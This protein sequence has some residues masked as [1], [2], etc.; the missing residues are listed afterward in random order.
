MNAPSKFFLCCALL[1]LVASSALADL[2]VVASSPSDQPAAQRLC[3]L[4]DEPARIVEDEGAADP[5]R[6]RALGRSHGA[7]RVVVFAGAAISVTD[8]AS[9]RRSAR[10]AE[11]SSAFTAAFVATELL[12]LQPAS[13]PSAASEP[14]PRLGFAL[15]LGL[16]LDR[17]RPFPLAPRAELGLALEHATWAR[18]SLRA[19]LF[20]A[21]P[22]RS[23][24]AEVQRTSSELGARMAFVLERAPLRI[25][26]AA[27]LGLGWVRARFDQA[28]YPDQ[29]R[30][31]VRAGLGVEPNYRLLPWLALYGGL[32]LQSSLPRAEYRVAGE[33]AARESPLGFTVS[34]GLWFAPPFR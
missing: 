2:L 7:A 5:E 6:A 4:H 3:E 23:Q 15:R 27:Q 34:A 31:I 13:T 11:N 26:F 29:T 18:A 32:A 21:P 33:R 20:G 30:K 9:G 22:G 16:Q 10:T 24:H 17:V 25:A 14:A 8:V 12:A 1:W 19:E 28:G